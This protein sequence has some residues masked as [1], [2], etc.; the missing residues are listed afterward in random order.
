MFNPD[1]INPKLFS[2]INDHKDHDIIFSRNRK[3]LKFYWICV[4]CERAVYCK[5]HEVIRAYNNIDRII[6]LAIELD[7]NEPKSDEP[8]QS[9]QLLYDAMAWLSNYCREEEINF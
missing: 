4:D 2:W 7:S 3:I 6:K 8:T 5:P 9:E 1:V